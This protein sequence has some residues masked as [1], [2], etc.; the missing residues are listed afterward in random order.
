[1]QYARPLYSE[2]IA[3]NSRRDQTLLYGAMT[4]AVP[5]SLRRENDSEGVATKVL[6]SYYRDK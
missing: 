1:M 5:T 4:E 6:K 3:A 2:W